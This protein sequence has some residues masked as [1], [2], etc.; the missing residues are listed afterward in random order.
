MADNE[1]GVDGVGRASGDLPADGRITRI[2][3]WNS[4]LGRCEHPRPG[5]GGPYY[6]IDCSTFLPYSPELALERGEWWVTA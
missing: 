2:S 5:Y 4:H 1:R 3:C 6:C